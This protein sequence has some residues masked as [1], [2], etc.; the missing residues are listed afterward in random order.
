M[1]ELKLSESRDLTRVERIGA[2]SHIRGLGLDSALEPRAVSEGMV[3]QV[4]ARKAA[5]VILQMIKEGKIA[6]RAILIAGQPGT[7][8][9]AIAMGMAKSLGLETPFAMIAG[10]EIFS[11]E[12][13]KTEALTQSFRKAIGVRIKEETEVIEG[14][15]VEVQIDRP[16]SSGVASKSGKLTMKTT[17]METVYDMGAKLIESL[18]KEKVQS[19]DVIALDK[20][21]GKIS[22]LGRSFSRSRDY[23][24]MGAQTKFVQCPDGELQKRKEVVHCVTLHE[25]DVINS[26]TQGFLALFTGDTGEIRSEVRE[27]IDTKVAE[28]REEG[29]A[30]IVPGVLF[31]D[32][33]HMLDIECFSF[34]NRAL[35][36]EMSPILVVATNRGVTTI[37]GTNQKSPHGIP[38]DL[39]DRLLIITTQPYT[40]EDIRK[41][42]EIRC[43]E[44]DVEMN[45]EAKQLLTLIG[46]DTSL[47]Y[48]IHLIT[49]AALSCQKRKGKVVEIEDINRVYRLF[50]DA[51]RSMQYLVEYQSQYMFSEPIEADGEDEQDAMQI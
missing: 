29:K 2:H 40:D 38:I 20:A 49:A 45:E 12:M 31:I 28:W 48:A 15:V 43:Q 4:K 35:E 19:G 37:R 46:R 51:R 18:N 39:L 10:S 22:K 34:L 30:E 17:D 11:L 44:E 27:Q 6:G 41:I 33:V 36:N 13:S 26:R 32:E 5:G 47:R 42:L 50:L 3:G 8:K 16:A 14:E 24:A 25:I 9:T 1:A 21:T 23:D 7:G